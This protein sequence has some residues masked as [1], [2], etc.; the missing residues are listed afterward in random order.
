M[1]S[2]FAGLM[3][4]A[5]AVSTGCNQGTPGGPGATERTAN[6]P[7]VERANDTFIL[8]VPMTST[9]LKQGET[10]EVAIS[11]ARGAKFDE[12]V[13]LKFTGLPKGVTLNPAS[14][15]IRHGEKD[16]K[17]TV[18]AADTAAPGDFRLNVT[19]KPTKGADAT[20]EF[21]ISIAKK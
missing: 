12:D 7:I 21:R 6:K 10:K 2:L 19:G 20:N 4:T 11:V 16:T 13:T 17:I 1:K 5:L 14:P 9:K 18:A 3:V 15:I 8:D